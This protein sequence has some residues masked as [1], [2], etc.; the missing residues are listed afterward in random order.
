MPLAGNT[1]NVSHPFEHLRHGDL[2]R[3]DALLVHLPLSRELRFRLDDEI[4]SIDEVFSRSV[5][6]HIRGIMLHDLCFETIAVLDSA[7]HDPCPGGRTGWG[8][9]ISFIEYHPF[10]SQPVDIWCGDVIHPIG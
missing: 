4:T 7:S 8:S 3:G 2:R 10:I 9:N 1:C 5:L 6:D